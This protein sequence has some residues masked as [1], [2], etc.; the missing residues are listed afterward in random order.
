MI[1]FISCLW[2]YCKALFYVWVF[3][4]PLCI[5]LA[6]W[7]H[8]ILF[9]PSVVFLLWK[10]EAD[11]RALCTGWLDVVALN[12][13]TLCAA[14]GVSFKKSAW[15]QSGPLL[16]EPGTEPPIPACV[17]STG[18]PG[19]LSLCLSVYLSLC[20]SSPVFSSVLVLSSSFPCCS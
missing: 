5:A 12:G 7:T 13:K 3:F 6:L 4:L 10:P 16:P 17:S 14:E 15:W 8:R 18:R 2:F 11:G 9:F 20:L 1:F 19:S